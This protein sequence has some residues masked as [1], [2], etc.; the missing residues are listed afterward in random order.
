MD[1]PSNMITVIKKATALGGTRRLEILEDVVIALPTHDLKDQVAKDFQVSC[2]STPDLPLSSIN[3]TLRKKIKS[4]YEIGAYKKARHLLMKEAI[5]NSIVAD[6]L[7]NTGKAYKAKGTVLTTHQKALF[8]NFENQNTL[9]FDEDPLSSALEIGTVSLNDLNSLKSRI[10]NRKIKERVQYFINIIESEGI[11]Y[12]IESTDQIALSDKELESIL[13]NM[14][15]DSN[16]L[17][18]LT[19]QFFAKDHEQ[20]PSK[21]R[22]LKHN[23]LNSD[24]LSHKKIIIISATVDE[25]IYRKLYGDRIHFVDVGNVEMQGIVVQDKKYSYSRSSLGQHHVRDYVLDKAKYYEHLIT[26]QSYK[27]YFPNAVEIM[28]YGKCAGFN[29]LKGKSLAVVGTPHL[30]TVD[31]LLYAKALGIEVSKEDFLLQ[32][33]RVEHNGYEFRFRTFVNPELQRVQFHFIEEQM[34]QAIGRARTLRHPVEVLLFS[35]FPLKCS[36]I[37]EDE[38]RQGR[39]QLESRKNSH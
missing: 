19:S 23:S 34:I 29:G 12:H 32:Q 11:K 9:I 21:L 14:E 1:A 7:D 33:L 28:H 18:F 24:N 16:V 36:L 30:K 38:I 8:I 17:K 31:Y 39:K 27:R 37:T 26:F 2:V 13:D 3:E 10:S 25:F 5:N 15:F 20:L 4:L 35:N 22:F 6:Y